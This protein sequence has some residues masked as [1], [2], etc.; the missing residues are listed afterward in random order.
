[1]G[2]ASSAKKVARAARA[3]G[4]K[5]SNQRRLAFP[6]AIGGIVVAG[7]L[8]IVVA[9]SG[10]SSVSTESPTPGEHWHAASGF[11][12][13][14][15]FQ[16][17]LVDVTAD[18]SGL[19]TH[20]DG[21]AHIHPFS[22]AYAGKNATLGNWGP[23]VGVDFGPDSWKL[24]DGT[25]YENGY[26]CNGQPATVS[27]YEWP[28]D[29][30]TAAPEVFTSNFGDIR[31]DTDRS[32]FTFAVVPEGTEVPKP[33]SI[34]TLDNLSDVAGSSATVPQATTLTV[35]V[36]SSTTVPPPTP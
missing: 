9:R 35:P 33:D 6:L 36:S 27:V 15:A 17:P 7:L 24:S 21:I 30:P 26:D 28:A 10:F 3:G 8:I 23:T 31:F 13:C 18:R 16:P 34:S 14:D 29:D 32:A 4:A 11:Y 5:Q 2:K 12:V 20:G 22:N 19:H 25:T 1:M